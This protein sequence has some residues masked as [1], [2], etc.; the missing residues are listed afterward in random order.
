ME[1]FRKLTPHDLAFGIGRKATK[2]E[3]EELVNRPQGKGKPIDEAV[4]DIK[5]RLAESKLKKAS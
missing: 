1:K 3:L 5:K 2:E 4:E